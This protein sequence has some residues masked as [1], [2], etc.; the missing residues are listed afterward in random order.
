VKGEDE[1]DGEGICGAEGYRSVLVVTE[2]AFKT[3]YI[4]KRSYNL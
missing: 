2:L 4:A 3:V 1:G